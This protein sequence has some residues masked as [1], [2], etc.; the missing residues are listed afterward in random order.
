MEINAIKR[1]EK[2]GVRRQESEVRIYS[3]QIS[4]VSNQ[5]D[6]AQGER[7]EKSGCRVLGTGNTNAK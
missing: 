7:R 5:K 1:L 2:T 3:C 6:G 4:V